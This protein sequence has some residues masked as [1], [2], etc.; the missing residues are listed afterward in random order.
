M[1]KLFDICQKYT[2][3]LLSGLTHYNHS[4]LEFILLQGGFHSA[5][6]SSARKSEFHPA[7]F[8]FMVMFPLRRLFFNWIMAIWTIVGLAL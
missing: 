2:F 3:L 7:I 8:L 6:S 4:L 1:E 5:S